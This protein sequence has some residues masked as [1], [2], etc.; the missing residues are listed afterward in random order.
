MKIF[1]YGT[2]ETD[3]HIVPVSDATRRLLCLQESNLVASEDELLA[4]YQR[5]KHELEFLRYENGRVSRC[6]RDAVSEMISELESDLKT[7]GNIINR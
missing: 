5:I 1:P 6:H 3:Y 7:I 4:A 2:T